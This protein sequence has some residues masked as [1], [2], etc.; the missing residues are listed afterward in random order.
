MKSSSPPL[1]TKIGSTFQKLHQLSEDKG[2]LLLD[3]V[4]HGLIARMIT[5][6]GVRVGVPP[7]TCVGE[8]LVYASDISLGRQGTE[9]MECPTR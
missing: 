1:V 7:H 3:E 8:S 6:G 5:C 4:R 9:N 2:V